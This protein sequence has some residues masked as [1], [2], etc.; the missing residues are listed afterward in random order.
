[1]SRTQQTLYKN[2]EIFSQ[3]VTWKDGTTDEAKRDCMSVARA[4]LEFLAKAEYRSGVSSLRDQ[5]AMAALQGIIANEGT[6]DI[7]D[8]A[9]SELV[10]NDV[11]RS[12]AYADVMLVERDKLPEAEAEKAAA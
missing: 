8:P 10:P 9:N 4:F 3:G 2:F 1:M 5:F 11:K 7:L 6:G 12:Y